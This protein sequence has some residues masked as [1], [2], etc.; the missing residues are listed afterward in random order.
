MVRV[1]VHIR[2]DFH[3]LGAHAWLARLVRTLLPRFFNDGE[4]L[5]K[6]FAEE[7]GIAPLLQL[8]RFR[9]IAQLLAAELVMLNLVSQEI[10]WL[11]FCQQ[12][13][14]RILVVKCFVLVRVA[15]VVEYLHG[16]STPRVS[17]LLDFQLVLKAHDLLCSWS[18]L[19]VEYKA[20]CKQ[21]VDERVVDLLVS[22][23]HVLDIYLSLSRSSSLEWVFLYHEVV[24]AAPQRPYVY[25]LRDLIATIGRKGSGLG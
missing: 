3:R 10:E 24:E 16:V 20:T 2:I 15:L 13:E 9:L 22:Y 8:W 18:V 5:R 11:R 12:S 25:S 1:N 21:F 23:R 14:V 6:R 17:E 4:A 19:T 7:P